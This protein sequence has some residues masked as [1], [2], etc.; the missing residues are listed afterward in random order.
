MR[1]PRRSGSSHMPPMQRITIAFLFAS[2][3][4]AQSTWVV[5]VAP[6][7][8]VHF[9]SLPVAVATAASG[10][11]LLV[12]AGQYEPFQASGKALTVRGAGSGATI[13]TGAAT[14][15][16]VRIQSVPVGGVFRLSGLTI[17]GTFAQ[18]PG[19]LNQLA[20]RGTSGSGSASLTD[21]VVDSSLG[22]GTA[23]LVNG[24]VVHANRC[25][26]N[27]GV[28][29]I[30]LP[31]GSAGETAVYVLAGANLIADACTITGWGAAFWY[32]VDTVGGAGLQVDNSAARLSR[33]DVRGGS[34]TG[35]VANSTGG[36]GIYLQ[37]A[38]TLDLVGTAAN[39]VRGGDA[40]MAVSGA[41]IPGRGISASPS[42]AGTLRV[43]GAPTIAAGTG[44]S[45]APAI[46]GVTAV[47]GPALPGMT[48]AGVVRPNGDLDAAQPVAATIDLGPANGIYALLFDLRPAF[49]LVPALTDEPLLLPSTAQFVEFGLLDAFGSHATTFTPATATPLLLGL[50][51]EL[52]AYVFD[53]GTG[54]WLG[55]NLEQRRAS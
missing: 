34:V 19:S 20:V 32:F 6:G 11:T 46:S 47:T 9:T 3:A 45:V 43:H 38:A 49:Q 26:F 48:L 22:A 29:T 24:C 25:T 35:G 42:L 7:P 10:D 30:S 44:S 2:A 31:P 54:R 12:A 5:D 16:F 51:M 39:L 17:R 28:R 13:I 52:Q 36:A 1:W 4:C 27:G 33:C 23:L 21:V 18:G 55:S 8:G 41:G 40:A 53:A 14:A 15:D 37:G 50:M